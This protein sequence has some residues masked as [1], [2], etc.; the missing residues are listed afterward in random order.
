MGYWRNLAN[1]GLLIGLTFLVPVS[2]FALPPQKNIS[3]IL[4]SEL[5]K[6]GEISPDKPLPAEDVPARPINETEPV[7]GGC[8][9]RSQVRTMKTMLQNARNLATRGKLEDAMNS[10]NEFVG[11]W[12]EVAQNLKR[13]SPKTHADINARINKIDDIFKKF[14]K[15]RQ[16]KQLRSKFI[17]EVT[18][19]INAI[20]QAG[21][22]CTI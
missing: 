3:G 14:S 11:P 16:R 17:K 8:L 4:A 5:L 9:S 15:T 2:S 18:N 19:L 20:D 7:D 10:Y 21:L 6:P 13:K 22:G 12:D 1:S